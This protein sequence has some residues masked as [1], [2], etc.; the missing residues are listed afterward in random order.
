M[1][2]H[3]RLQTKEEFGLPGG[4]SAVEGSL[5]DPPIVLRQDRLKLSLSSLAPTVVGGLVLPILN[6]ARAR[7]TPSS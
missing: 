7:W 4:M 6:E 1:T 5:D 2:R 3:A